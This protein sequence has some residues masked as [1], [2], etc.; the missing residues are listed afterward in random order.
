METKST[1]ILLNSVYGNIPNEKN[2]CVF[3]LPIPKDYFDR[4][5]EEMNKFRRYDMGG[6]RGI[7]FPNEKNNK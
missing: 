3:A 4:M 5:R 2:P 1:Q 6:N 7:H